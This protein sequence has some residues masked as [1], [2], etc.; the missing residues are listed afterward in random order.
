MDEPPV[1]IYVMGDN[2]WRG[3]REWPLARTVWTKFYL[4]SGGGAN[5]CEGDGRLDSTAPTTAEPSDSYVYDPNNPV[6]TV[7]GPTVQPGA[8]IGA[9]AG[10]K[11]QARVESR[12]DVLVYSTAPLEQEVEVTGPITACLIA[13]SSAL[14][15]DWTVKLVD[16]HPDGRAYNLADGIC[17]ARYRN[18]SDHADFL[19]PGKAYAYEDRPASYQQCFQSRPQNSFTGQQ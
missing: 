16:V 14:D 11:D 9:N 18:G 8:G 19:E 12:A 1:L 17:R 3:E 4:H 10:P 15:T 5:T 13:A 7:G 2:K 6:P